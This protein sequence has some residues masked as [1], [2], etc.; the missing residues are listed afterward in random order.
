MYLYK[1]KPFIALLFTVLIV[2]CSSDSDDNSNS[3]NQIN[4]PSWIQGTWINEFDTGGFRFTADDLCVITGNL[5][6]CYKQILE[7][8]DGTVVEEEVD[9]VITDELYFI[10]FTLAGSVTTYE[11]EKVSDTE[12]RYVDD[13]SNPILTKQ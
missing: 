11:F 10:E 7:Q 4:P 12:I 13:I 3:N 2:S 6:Q 9:E 8:T 5:Q 1:L